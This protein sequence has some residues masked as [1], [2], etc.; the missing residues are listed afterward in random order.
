M[1]DQ[2]IWYKKIM[3]IL[4]S[5]LGNLNSHLIM[6]C[7]LSYKNAL[8]RNIKIKNKGKLLNISLNVINMIILM[9]NLDFV[10]SSL[11]I[12]MFY[13]SLIWN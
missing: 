12:I 7:H 13:Y 9:I 4:I 6:L 10:L 1:S 2:K 8:R 11:F 3:G 5:L